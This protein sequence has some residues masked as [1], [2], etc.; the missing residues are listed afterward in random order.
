[1]FEMQARLAPLNGFDGE[2]RTRKRLALP[3]TNASAPIFLDAAYELDVSANE[4]VV[5]RESFGSQEMSTLLA[6]STSKESS[7]SLQSLASSQ[8]PATPSE[9][10]A[11]RKMLEH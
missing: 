5:V 8:E 6:P 2:G 3:A 9:C 11:L 4:G 10:D 7:Q 1:M